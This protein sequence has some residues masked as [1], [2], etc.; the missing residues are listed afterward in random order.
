MPTGQA[1]Q[2]LHTARNCTAIG[3]LYEQSPYRVLMNSP[4]SYEGYNIT[5]DMNGE[6][7]AIQLSSAM[8]YPPL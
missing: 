8:D 4:V 2:L 5:G 1:V 6:F 7:H 3:Q